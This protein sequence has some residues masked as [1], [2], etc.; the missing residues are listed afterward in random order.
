[1]NKSELHPSDQDLLLAADGELSRGRAKR[2]RKHLDACWLCRS[3][4]RELENTIADFVHLYQRSAQAELPSLS[5]RR[6]LLKAQLTERG[7]KPQVGM[8]PRFTQFALSPRTLACVYAVL[9]L[10]ATGSMALVHQFRGQ[11]P[12][13]AASEINDDALPN[14][15]L[16]PGATRPVAI[17]DVCS[18]AH[19]EVVRAVPISLRQ[20][21]FR[22][23]GIEHPRAENYEIDYLIA[24]GLG[25]KEDIHNLWPEPYTATIWNAHV[26]DA[27]EEHLHEMVCA[28]KLDLPTAQS[29]IAK[30][31]IAA[32]KKYFHTN[33][34]LVANGRSAFSAFMGDATR[35]RL[36]LTG[37]AE[38]G[39]SG[40][41]SAVVAGDRAHLLMRIANCPR[42]GCDFAL[43]ELR[44]LQMNRA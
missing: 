11:I 20:Q 28:G 22:E 34:P 18:M 37:R 6:A 12:S 16:T 23:Y 26:K 5:A 19:E 1:M 29:E 24:P 32:Y 27:L 44:R 38:G 21:V 31:W 7:A 17:S 39:F 13:Q 43:I 40:L 14:R 35:D 15:T 3:R 8:W 4:L 9:L 36:E 10:V 41:D 25:G 30:D 42:L 2:V 33:E